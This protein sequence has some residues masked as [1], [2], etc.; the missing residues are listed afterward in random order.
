MASRLKNLSE[1]NPASVASARGMRLGVVVSDYHAAI[2]QRLLDGCLRTLLRC[3]ARHNDIIVAHVPGAFELPA[4]A[5][6]LASSGRFDALICLGCVIKGQTRHDEYINRAVAGGI[7]QL[8]LLIK[9]P[10]VYGVL[11]TDNLKQAKERAGGRFGNKGVEAAGAAVRMAA[12]KDALRQSKGMS[13]AE[14][15]RREKQA[16]N[17]RK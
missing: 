6:L 16:R 12:L 11:T 4:G 14:R 9:T 5:H 17:N 13:P 7:I 10:V 1:F 3:G 15:Q 2:T 8:S